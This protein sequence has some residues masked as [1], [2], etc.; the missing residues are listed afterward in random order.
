VLFFLRYFSEVMLLMYL[1]LL[2]HFFFQ[3]RVFSCFEKS[4]AISSGNSP[5]GHGF[6]DPAGVLLLLFLL[7]FK[8]LIY[9]QHVLKL[10]CTAM[11]GNIPRGA[12]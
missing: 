12:S 6:Y 5:A 8:S 10:P 4:N 9:S 7:C 1:S 3:V 11:P 2:K